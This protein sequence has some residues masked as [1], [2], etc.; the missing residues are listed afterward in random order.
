MYNIAYV[1][2]CGSSVVLNAIDNLKHVTDYIPDNTILL[3]RDP[4]DRMVVEQ[5]HKLDNADDFDEAYPDR[6]FEDLLFDVR[7]PMSRNLKLDKILNIDLDS[8]EL[9]SP[10]IKRSIFEFLQDFYLVGLFNCYDWPDDRIAYNPEFTVQTFVNEFCEKT[11][12]KAPTIN[13]EHKIDFV[14][15]DLGLRGKYTTFNRV[16]YIVTSVIK[17]VLRHKE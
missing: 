5:I 2:K 12:T 9:P 6:T 17:N 4:F 13:V 11:K 14:N 3:L 16:D 10:E 15:L 7:N 8:P 1:P